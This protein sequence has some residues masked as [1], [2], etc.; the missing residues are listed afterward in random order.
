MPVFQETSSS[1]RDLRILP[2]R[3]LP[4]PR[5]SDKPDYTNTV[6]EQREVVVIG[7]GPSGLFLT[8]LLAR[9]GLG[10]SS[11]L[12][13]DSKPGTLKAGQADG[14]Q[15]RTLEVF[16]SLGIASELIGEGCHMEEVAFWNPASDGKGIERTSFTPDVNVPARFPFEV[17]I[18]QGRIERIL[19]ENLHLYTGNQ[20]IRRSHRFLEYTVDEANAEFPI[21]VKYE[22]DLA[23]GS[24]QQKTVRTKY[25]IGADGARSK[26]RKC[27]GLELEGETTDHI[28]G[29]CDF[30]ADTNFP[31]IRNRSAVHSDAGSVM[32]IPREQIATGD[33]LTRLYVQVPGEVEATQDA[34]MDKK[35]A[36]KKRRGA[37]TL[38]YIFEQARAVFAPYEIKIK[39][40]T[41]PDWWA[42]YQIGQRM[43]PNFSAKTFDGLERVFI[44]GDACHTH[45]PKAGQGMNVS[46]MDSFNL[47]WKLVHSLHGL[48]PTS[49]TGSADPVLETFSPERKDV[50]RQLIEFD[51][52][53]SHMFS[54]RI[55][56]ADAETSGLTHE[57]F[58]RVFS[59][60]SGFTSGCGLQYKPGRL[61]QTL[62]EESQ[63]GL[64]RGDPLS[65]A[66]T[67]GRRLLDV[68]VKRYADA[69]HRHLQDEM[70]PTG[71]Y[72]L[73]VFASNDLLDRSGA[74]Q[75]A[76]QSSIDIISKF[77][78]ETINLV[79]IHPLTTR[80][81][82]T[83]IPAG[84]KK[85]AEMRVYGLA[86]RDDAYETLGVSKD[87]G[88]IAVVRPDGY[89]GMLAPLSRVGSVEKHLHSGEI[90]RILS[91][92]EAL[93]LYYAGKPIAERLVTS[94]FRVLSYDHPGHGQSSALKDVNKVKFEE[95]IN[96]IDEL[97]HGK[98]IH[99]IRAWIGLSLGAASGVYM[100]H[101]RPGLIQHLI[102]CGCPPASLSVLGIMSL[103][104][105][106]KMRDEAEKDGSTTNAIR[107][108][109][110]GWASKEWLDSN[111][112]QDERLKIASSTL[113]MDAWRAMMTLQKDDDFDMRPLVPDLME[114]HIKIMLVKG[115]ND[116][117]INP[118]VNMMSEIVMKI[119]K[120]KAVEGNVKVV[121]VPNSGHVIII[122][123]QSIQP[124]RPLNSLIQRSGPT[125]TA[126][127]GN[128]GAITIRQKLTR[129]S[130]ASNTYTLPG[131]ISQQVGGAH[132]YVKREGLNHTGAHKI[133]HCV[134]FALLAKAMGKT[135]LIAETGAGQHGVALA[136]AAAY[137]GLE[138][139][140]HMGA[141][142]IEKQKSNAG[143]MQ[144]LG[145]RV[146][147]AT[148]GQSA[149]KDASD[150]AFNAYIEQREHALYAIGSAIGPHPFPLIVRDFQ[151]VIG[152]ESREQ[153]LAMT[154]GKLPE[155][156][157][158][159]VAG[160]SN[161]MGMYSAF[162][163]DKDV[164]LHAI[165]P[166]GRSDQPGQHAAT[167][168]YGKPGTLHGAKTLVIQK[169]GGF[170]A[171]VSSV[172]SGLVYPGVGP[173]MAML[174]E[175]GRVS[176]AA[177]RDE[178]VI[179][180]FFKMAKI[181]GI[182]IAL[183]SAHAVAFAIRLA[184][185][186]PKSE[187]IL[188]NLSGRGDKD[189]DY[190]LQN[191]GTG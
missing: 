46:M 172:A 89:V 151:S 68:E 74:S 141:I 52:K 4:L 49:T 26:V 165:E 54:G 110:Y 136:T 159:C 111:P 121:T 139:E 167:L 147:S 48:T 157:V 182:I 166:L 72:Y 164:K 77:P 107:H 83:D 11:L 85:L 9:Y 130:R 92:C 132:I 17:T 124:W 125:R 12:C 88:V 169:E 5:L 34:G 2:S 33:Y 146:I 80:F 180:T 150:S 23:D 128:L 32:I 43:A 103:K 29:V 153:F 178:E 58:L 154:N 145:A 187:R 142:D 15:P 30:V 104:Q 61:V 97:L 138:C 144:I 133:N 47:A 42:A 129:P 149:L 7:A 76:L 127:L 131:N 177:I 28:W 179:S 184:A 6:E 24:T 173:E 39:E 120:D 50:A 183:E 82:W 188:V 135:K 168:S 118:F 119:A 137:F 63:N 94:G 109:H 20:T 69:T 114:S 91:I 99:S 122:P 44:V 40:G 14:L 84:V 25:L 65:G 126:T 37:V 189:V 67:P 181:E 106:D 100:A 162:I 158:A 117:R 163:E 134:G 36:D 156:V 176:V 101:R 59:E 18:H 38:D 191:H 71:R 19:E 70:P 102:Y 75:S 16:Q 155:H 64:F 112:D 79:V 27:M 115:E 148:K 113:S 140:I 55:G 62:D 108:M 171:S 87:D 21:V 60:G 57:E 41:E 93:Q 53:F 10:E 13:L 35:S 123:I 185:E 31:D 161:A 73:L 90:P 3:A 95:I 78:Q 96:D 45:S 143:R 116:A 98:E 8:L 152:H 186:R 190:V 105:I 160:G 56:S 81:E 51:T 1:A 170:P 174:H 22:H 86:R 66:L 175:G